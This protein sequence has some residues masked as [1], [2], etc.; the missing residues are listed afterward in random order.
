MIKY[1]AEHDPQLH[2]H[3]TVE[4]KDEKIHEQQEEDM[5]QH[6]AKICSSNGVELEGC[7]KQ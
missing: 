7:S 5:V 2:E 4:H 6:Y 3:L 1:L